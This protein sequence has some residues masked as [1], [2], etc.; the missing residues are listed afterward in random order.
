MWLYTAQNMEHTRS[1]F[2]W[3]EKKTEIG[4]RKILKDWSW[5]FSGQAVGTVMA[6][7]LAVGYANFLTQ[8][9]YGTYKYVLA[10]LGILAVFSLPG[11]GD[12]VQRSTAQGAEGIFWRT[13]RKRVE[14]SFV[15]SLLSFAIA[16]YYFINGNLLL[17][18][19][20]A[21][22]APFLLV[23]DPL[24]HYQALLMGRRRY[25]QVSF[26]NIGIQVVSA[27]ALFFAVFFSNNVAIL[28]LVYFASFS[29][30]RAVAFWHAIQQAPP[31]TTK[32]D[33]AMR[34]GGHMSI[35][36][37]FG[38][39]AGQLDTILLWQFL[40]PVPL[41]VY[42]FAQAAADHARKAFKVATTSM[43]FPTFSGQDK[44]VLKK[45]LPKKIFI[46]HLV[47]VPLAV[48]L[49][50]IVPYL[51]IFLFPA[52]LDSIPYAQ[53]MMLL[54]AFSPIRF[55][56]TAVNAHASI[57]DIYKMNLTASITHIA[58]LMALVPVLGIWGAI[59]ASPVQT[60]ISNVVSYRIFRNM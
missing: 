45:T 19:A 35:L 56:S 15:G 43:A 55:I 20:F 9:V 48:V 8:E 59:L 23:T 28:I 39:V 37:V 41:A 26:Y 53:I 36:N 17:A 60:M 25:Q 50:L 22:A 13:F 42:S 29:I 10:I 6:L 11:M 14:W 18:S 58:A 5:L 31:N 3:V 1:V 34:F 52:Y 30:L 40:G 57:K 12:A 16:A 33:E 4:L 27:I 38:F 24:N 7:L 44:E 32:D 49:A 2:I 21:V 51:Y 47:T 54:L 46:A